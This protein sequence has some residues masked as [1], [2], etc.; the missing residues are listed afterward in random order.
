MDD[1]RKKAA[2]RAKEKDLSYAGALLPAEAHELAQA[3]AK[4]VD[5]RTKPELQ[6]VGKIPGSIAIEWQTWPGSRPNPD[7]VSSSFRRWCSA[8]RRSCSSAA[9]V[10]APM[11]RRRPPQAPATRTPT[12]CS[13]DSRATRTATGIAIRSAAGA[14]PACR[15]RR[16]DFQK[17]TFKRRRRR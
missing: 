7:F 17:R 2:E 8:M 9:P 13:R 4:L 10:R 3:G 12:T 14:K 15:G 16:A 5:V 11:E 1:I 6:Y